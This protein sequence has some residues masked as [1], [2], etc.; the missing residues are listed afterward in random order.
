MKSITTRRLFRLIPK[1]PIPSSSATQAP[2]GENRGD[3]RVPV[4]GL[5]ISGHQIMSGRNRVGCRNTA[6]WD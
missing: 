6:E 5:L 1:P 2:I 3:R 4:E